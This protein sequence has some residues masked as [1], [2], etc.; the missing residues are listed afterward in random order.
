MAEELSAVEASE[1]KVGVKPVEGLAAQ[2]AYAEIVQLTQDTHA[3]QVDFLH[4]DPTTIDIQENSA[5]AHLVARV[6]IP[7]SALKSVAELF[8][9]AVEQ[10]DSP[11]ES[12]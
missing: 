3:A 8:A 6:I 7:K 12:D 1:V 9:R 10:G 11:T 2:G 4:I 5:T